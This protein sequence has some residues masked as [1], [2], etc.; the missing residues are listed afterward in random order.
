MGIVLPAL[1][2]GVLRQC[3][4]LRVIGKEALSGLTVGLLLGAVLGPV[5]HYLGGVS[6]H[7]STVVFCTLPLT[8][9]I[10]GTL[11]ATIPFAC[12]AVGLD[13]ALVAA[14]AMTTLVDV[15]GL[16]GYFVLANRIFQLFGMEL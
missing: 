11:A 10:A 13:P 8:S 3:D 4:A 1:S 16:L 14:P 9:T 15:T 7:V 2:V 12:R 6:V 5:A